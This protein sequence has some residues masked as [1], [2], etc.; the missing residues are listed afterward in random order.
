MNNYTRNDVYL[1]WSQKLIIEAFLHCLILSGNI[2]R[3]SCLQDVI[4]MC[5]SRCTATETGLMNMKWNATVINEPTVKLRRKRKKKK[6]VEILVTYVLFSFL[7]RSSRIYLYTC[8]E[9]LLKYLSVTPLLKKRIA[10]KQW[11]EK[12]R[13]DSIVI[14][15][16]KVRN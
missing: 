3:K 11:E 15:W 16:G 12:I 6:K 13:G 1:L 14:S 5:F 4:F 2:K 9:Q 10:E 7:N 8:W